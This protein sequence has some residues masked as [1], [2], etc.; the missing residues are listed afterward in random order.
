MWRSQTLVWPWANK[1]VSLKVELNSRLLRLAATVQAME[2][3][4][5]RKSRCLFMLMYFMTT[6]TT[7]PTEKALFI[8]RSTK[9]HLTLRNWQTLNDPCTMRDHAEWSSMVRQTDGY[10]KRKWMAKS[11]N[12]GWNLQIKST[13]TDYFWYGVSLTTLQPD[14]Q[15][16]LLLIDSSHQ[17]L[18]AMHNRSQKNRL[19]AAR[20]L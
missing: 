17:E 6:I 8:T 16:R 19:R 15:W 1:N 14:R 7:C 4:P 11:R 9:W 13:S 18:C 3:E 12:D 10:S 2:T 20:R 5:Y